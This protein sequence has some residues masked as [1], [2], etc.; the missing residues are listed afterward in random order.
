M[1]KYN[2]FQYIKKRCKEANTKSKSGGKKS[3]K[4]KKT[5]STTKSRSNAKSTS[6]AGKA[7]ETRKRNAQ[8]AI[9][10]KKVVKEVDLWIAVAVALVLFLSNFGVC[11]IIGERLSS[12]MLGTFVW[13]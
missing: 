9:T 6:R 12:V 5:T 13:M 3:N 10:H 4:K 1:C 8:K 7:S 2:Q 11:G